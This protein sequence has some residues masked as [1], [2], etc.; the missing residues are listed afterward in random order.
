VAF[1]E[2][3]GLPEMLGGVVST[4][5]TERDTG[6]DDVN[7]PESVAVHVIEA[8]P[9]TGTVWVCGPIPQSAGAP[10]RPSSVSLVETVQVIVA[11][12]CPVAS[13]FPLGPDMETEGGVLG[14]GSVVVPGP[15]P[16]A[17]MGKRPDVSNVETDATAYPTKATTPMPI[18]ISSAMSVRRC[19]RMLRR[20][21]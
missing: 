14:G 10:L 13:T 17:P 2:P 6:G 18:A 4:T 16:L 11:P 1:A 19:L 8:V 15:V 21:W 5:V 12:F 3:L 7:P 9:P 20:R